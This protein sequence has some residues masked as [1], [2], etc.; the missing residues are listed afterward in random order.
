MGYNYK[1][2]IF[3]KWKVKGKK[4]FLKKYLK[5]YIK[6]NIKGIEIIYFWYL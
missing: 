5:I 4:E 1:F 6:V 3:L 2:I